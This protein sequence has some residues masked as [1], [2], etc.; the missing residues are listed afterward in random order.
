MKAILY[1][2][3][4]GL[5]KLEYVDV[6]DPEPG[7]GQVVIR[8]GACSLN[9]TLDIETR[10]NGYMNPSLPHIGGTDPAGEVMSVGAGVQRAKIGDRVAVSP[11]FFCGTCPPCRSGR[12][13]ICERP[14]VFGVHHQGGFAEYAAIPDSQ[15]IPLPETMTFDQ[16]A[17]ISLSYSTA[18]HLLV[19]RARIGPTDTVLILAS[20]SGL[21]VAGTQ[22]ARLLGAR[23]IAA[24]GS[25]AKLAR[26]RELG[27]DET[28]NY[29]TTDFSEA[30]KEL[31]GG[32]GVDV[33][34]ENIG[35][36]TWDKSIA[37]LAKG[38]R[39]VTCGVHGGATAD[40][41]IRML[42]FREISLLFS[43]GAIPSEINQV[44]DLVGQGK[45]EA[46][47]DSVYP[48]PEMV[49]AQERLLSR[50]IFGKVII[51]P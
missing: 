28:I 36:D 17:A 6:P 44:F 35:T 21:G 50:D 10:L 34:F 22:I 26:S 14:S 4:G 12:T 31:T 40:I 46:V 51:H 5:E 42:Y 19:G 23:V 16:A 32:R 30:V 25:D 15:I 3:L 48:L 49:A 29:T 38:G 18:W 41:N 2:E 1:R 13:N 27:A 47:I 45:I 7:P 33:V 43:V 8:V 37:S 20:G 11:Y 39:L 9:R 24:A